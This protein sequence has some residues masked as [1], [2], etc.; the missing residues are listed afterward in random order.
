MQY[1][2]CRYEIDKTKK[3]EDGLGRFP[4]IYL[5]GCAVTGKS[6]AV[7]MLLAKHPEVSCQIYWMDLEIKDKAG[8]LSKL[9]KEKK[10]METEKRWIVFENI[11]ADLDLEIAAECAELVRGIENDSRLIFVSRKKPRI[12][13]L[14]LLWSGSMELITM[15]HLLFSPEEVRV[16][17]EISKSRWNAKELY[18]KTSGWPGVVY[19]LV[20]LRSEQEKQEKERRLP[21]F[22]TYEMKEYIAQE[23]LSELD[24]EE[25][26]LLQHIA[27]CPW[28]TEQFCSQVWGVAESPKLLHGLH[29]K[30]MLHYHVS[31]KCWS[32]NGLFLHYVQPIKPSAGLEDV[33]YEK[34][35][36]VEEAF[37]CLEQ[38]GDDEKYHECLLRHYESAA[39]TGHITKKVLQWKGSDIRDCYFRG[40]HYYHTK[41]FQGLEEEIR[42]LSELEDQTLQI[43]ELLLNLTY[44]NP[45][46]TL[47]DWLQKLEEY[48]KDGSRFHLYHILGTGASCLCGLRDL[49]F[50]FCGTI[51]EVRRREKLWKNAFYDYEWKCYQ[52]A[53]IDF[54]LETNQKEAILE[55]DLRILEADEE[56]EM[57]QLRI[58]KLYLLCKLQRENPE[59]IYAKRIS[60]LEES[61]NRE[62]FRIAAKNSE[63]ISSLYSPW[64]GEKER[65]T[66]WLL[67]GAFDK[68]KV[69]EDENYLQYYCAAKGYLLLNQYDKA[70]KL[71]QK[72]TVYL[73]PYHRNRLMGE[74]LFQQGIIFWKK[75]L[76]GQAV[77]CMIESVLLCGASRYV[78]FYASYG[79]RGYPLLEA[80]VE[81]QKTNAP[82]GWSRKKKYNYG[83][84]LRMPMADYMQVV[85]RTTKKVSKSSGK[86]PKESFEEHLTMM[87]IMI[88]QNIGHGLSNTQICDALGLKLPT[89]KGHAYNLYRKL[90][91]ENRTQ[92]VSKGRELGLIE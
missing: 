45:K 43:K 8:L 48:T 79:Q 80:F 65:L 57:W 55:E 73:Q 49:S 82:E 53:R 54:Y 70:E 17:V 71:I 58:N 27:G 86:Y 88:L 1:G 84:V 66:R 78:G 62:R 11:P 60:K 5:E 33:W 74:L 76:K 26:E 92:A 63:A 37:R 4:S 39:A 35:G 29:R 46:M 13:F 51:K 22:E 6:V 68:R 23:I 18:E 21:L 72:L 41:N 85:L 61:L 56:N 50:L 30:G 64:Y 32:M 87:E 25:Q 40:V 19:M 2:N 36:F 42:T 81:W 59:K 16:Y 31:R 77:R 44:L 34:H 67:D 14:K 3:L 91:V 83:N 75:D 38:A 47:E 20:R 69:I 9:Q 10:R 12:E 28:V 24:D 15:D 89:V 52:Y 90:G 7:K